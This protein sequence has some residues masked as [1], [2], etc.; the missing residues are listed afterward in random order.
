MHVHSYWSFIERTNTNWVSESSLWGK[1]IKYTSDLNPKDFE[2]GPINRAWW[3]DWVSNHFLESCHIKKKA[4]CSSLGHCSAPVQ[5]SETSLNCTNQNIRGEIAPPIRAYN[6]D[7]ILINNSTVQFCVL[8]CFTGAIE[9]QVASEWSQQ[10][11]C[12]PYLLFDMLQMALGKS[13]AIL[14]N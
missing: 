13:F 9:E 12:T 8:K 3:S 5:F 2:A 14:S 10:A 1:L 7:G 11:T 6:K 4:F